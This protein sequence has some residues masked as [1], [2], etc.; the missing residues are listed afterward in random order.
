MKTDDFGA[1]LLDRRVKV[2]ALQFFIGSGRLFVPRFAIYASASTGFLF[3]YLLFLI[4]NLNLHG[5]VL[6][7]G[8]ALFTLVFWAETIRIFRLQ[9]F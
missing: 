3:S 2:G 5:L 8:H 9:P 6:L 1:Y 7:I 4:P